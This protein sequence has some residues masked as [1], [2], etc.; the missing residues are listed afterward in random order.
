MQ[1]SSIASLFKL[2]YFADERSQS[3][4]FVLVDSRSASRLVAMTLLINQCDAN[5]NLQKE[6]KS[7]APGQLYM[8]KIMTLHLKDACSANAAMTTSMS[9]SVALFVILVGQQ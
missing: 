7:T 2:V 9:A 4:C 8:C 3:D 6:S 5:C 1:A